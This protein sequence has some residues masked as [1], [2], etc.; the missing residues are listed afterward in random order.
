MPQINAFVNMLNSYLFHPWVVYAL[1]FCG[2]LFTIWSAFGQYR[3]LTHGVAVTRGK[4]DDKKDPGAINHF[5]ALSAALSATVGLGNI[6]G[7][8][9]AVAL[10][11]PGAILWM[12]VIG[13]VGMAL[14]MTEVTQSMLYRNTD[15]PENPHGGPMF[16]VKNGLTGPDKK[17]IALALALAFSVAII[18]LT[19]LSGNAIA[20]AVGLVISLGLVGLAVTTHSTLGSVIGGV[21]VVTLI[22]SAITGGN[23]F[24][25][26]NVADITF[27]YFEVP[28]V[29]TGIILAV[30]VGLVI[31]GGIKRIGSFA[32][33]IVPFMCFIYI[34][35]AAFVLFKNFGTIPSSIALIFK[36]GLPEFLGGSAPD[37]TGAFLGGTFGYAA[38]WGVKRALFSS[39]AGQGSSPI[40]HSAAK[41]DEPVREGIVAGLE[42]FIDTLV[43]CSLTALVILSTG[44][45]NRES[46]AVYASDAVVAVEFVSQEAAVVVTESSPKQ[47][48]GG[49][50]FQNIP[51]P[52]RI[53]TSAERDASTK[54]GKPLPPWNKGDSI[55]SYVE[56]QPGNQ[57]RVVRGKV[58]GGKGE[59]IEIEFEMLQALDDE[60]AIES[61][62][63][64]GTLYHG[65]APTWTVKTGPLPNLTDSAR[66][67]R[68]TAEGASGWRDG[69]SV[70]VI[71][72]AD[73]S[74]DTGRTLRRISGTVTRGP[75][76]TWSVQ[77]GTLASNIQPT[78]R[79]GPDSQP[80]VGIYGD[81]AGASMTAYAF[82]RAA[83]GLGKVV[84]TIAAWLFAISTMIS[85]SYYGEQGVYFIFG[86]LGGRRTMTAVYLYK[87]IY[88]L[89]IFLTGVAAMKIFPNATEGGPK[90]AIIATDGELDMW[91]TLGL[92]VM[93][94]A[95]IPIMLVFSSH[96]MKAYHT[97]IG[98][99]KRGEL[100]S[101][102]APPLEDVMGGKDVE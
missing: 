63:R 44:A 96:A 19:A 13:V 57:T 55:F 69:E 71:V 15:D 12:W 17:P 94:V 37:A 87:F 50:K 7:V 33:R 59:P 76:D 79:I 14:K 89:L 34:L 39:E 23:M 49:W 93:L 91:T 80:D 92:G 83:P 97:Y 5:Q 73:M 100:D 30:L 43:V 86:R 85:W 99:L 90:V 31:I 72:N 24:Q 42:P 41:T 66:R 61:A 88:C 3:A 40:A 8:A 32:G 29:V 47:E 20:I 65:A 10:G 28:Q 81:Y 11:G 35:A 4:Y 62:S 70:F 58:V 27:T 77:W 102:A 53:P 56:V 98:K 46:E 18:T 25:A 101:H 16:V 54:S 64:Q 95:N 82:D 68:R 60:E 75:E 36:S 84:V 9:V 67:I 78:L 74:S 51:A 26:W 22:I 1:L 2:V 6:G 45:Y 38:M 52:E 21:F 48:E